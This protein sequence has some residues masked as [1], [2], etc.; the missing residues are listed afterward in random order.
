MAGGASI[1]KKKKKSKWF[2]SRFME[3]VCAF[4]FHSE[5]V[6]LVYFIFIFHGAGA[7]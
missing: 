2:V 6:K 3:L 7:G 1:K 5:I 4:M